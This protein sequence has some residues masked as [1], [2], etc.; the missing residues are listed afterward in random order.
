MTMCAAHPVHPTP[1]KQGFAFAPGKTAFVVS[2]HSLFKGSH[3]SC[4]F[5]FD[6]TGLDKFGDEIAVRVGSQD[7]KVL[8]VV[9]WELRETNTCV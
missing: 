2:V 8:D 9:A 5:D 7:S 6:R 1:V 4:A 3:E